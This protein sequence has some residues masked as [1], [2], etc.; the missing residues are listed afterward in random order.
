[1]ASCGHAAREGRGG[2][3]TGGASPGA[4]TLGHARQR[5][6]KREREKG[7]GGGDRRVGPTQGGAQLTEAREQVTYGAGY[8][9][10]GLD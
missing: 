9:A 8:S 2:P 1:V 4:A 6:G 7:E 5:Q 10:D 3:D